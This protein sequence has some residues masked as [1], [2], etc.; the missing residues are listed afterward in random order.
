MTEASV[1]VQELQSVLERIIH[2]QVPIHVG[3]SLLSAMFHNGNGLV[4]YDFDEFDSLLAD[5]P[6][7]DQYPYWNQE[8][9]HDKLKK[10]DEYEE[11][12]IGLAKQLF[13]KLKHA[14]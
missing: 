14:E 3:C 9:L 6:F 13:E 4:W 10:L 11:Q 8:A 2:K 7:P 12:V 1:Q 5:V